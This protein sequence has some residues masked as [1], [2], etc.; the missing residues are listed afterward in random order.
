[1]ADP[2]SPSRQPPAAAAVRR[3]VPRRAERQ[4]V[5][6][7]ARHPGRLSRYGERERRPRSSSP[8]RR[9]LFILPYFLFSATAGQLADKYEKTQLIRIAEAVG[10]RRDGARR[11]RASRSTSIGFR[12]TVLFLLGVQATFFGPV[13]Y[14]ILPELLAPEELVG[15][16]ALIEAGTFL[17]ILIG[18][19]A[20]GLL[21]LAP[22]GRAIVTRDAAR[23]CRRRLGRQPLHPA[24][25]RAPR[26]ICASIPTSLAETWRSCATPMRS[27]E[28]RWPI[29]GNSW[30]WF[31][32]DRL[33]RAVPELRQGHAGRQ[34]PGRDAVPD[35]VL[36]RHRRRLAARAGG[37]R[38]GAINA[39]LVPVR[40]AG[41]AL[42]GF[43]LWLAGRPAQRQRAACR[44]RGVPGGAGALAH[45]RRPLRH[46]ARRR[47]IYCVPL[48]AMMQARSET[49]APRAR[50][51][52]QQHHE[53]AVHGRSPALR[54]RRR[55]W[56]SASASADIFLARRDRQRR[57]SRAATAWRLRHER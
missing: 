28:L 56:R 30:F 4:S 43:D 38:H 15:G 34:Q 19:I 20:G 48:Y 31:V 35:A 36:A 54:Q 22:H 50:H 40:R 21:I 52:R 41:L 44:R 57:R 37:C 24:R 23:L 46:R 55:C 39:R 27:R 7:R 13:K 16:N 53:C 42:F 11:R 5:Q 29:L 3:A 12:L 26:R 49:A 2:A 14:G 45:R 25:P 18:T 6:E 47:G 1:M 51:R 10:N 8:S 33:S 17:A 32:G 9:A